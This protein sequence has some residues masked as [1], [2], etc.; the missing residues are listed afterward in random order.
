MLAYAKALDRDDLGLGDGVGVVNHRVAETLDVVT[1]GFAGP[2]SGGI[3]TLDGRLNLLEAG[4][5]IAASTVGQICGNP[6]L[7]V[8]GQGGGSRS[9]GSLS[10]RYASRE[11]GLGSHRDASNSNTTIDGGGGVLKIH[12]V[13]LAAEGEVGVENA[14]A[15]QFVEQGFDLGVLNVETEGAPLTSTSGISNS[16]WAVLER[17]V[18]VMSWTLNGVLF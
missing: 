5:E 3:A 7:H 11:R 16:P 9:H 18:R 15:P 10:H 12:A 13:E 4:A 14:S 17:M 2:A 1:Q 6:G 8:R